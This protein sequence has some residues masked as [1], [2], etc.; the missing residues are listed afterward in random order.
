MQNKATVYYTI[1]DIPHDEFLNWNDAM[2][3]IEQQLNGEYQVVNGKF[4][5][6]LVDW[7]ETESRL[8]NIC[9]VELH[10]KHVEN[11]YYQNGGQLF[12]LIKNVDLYQL[13][14][15]IL[16]GKNKFKILKLHVDDNCFALDEIILNEME[17]FSDLYEI[18][19]PVS[20]TRYRDL[21]ILK[22]SF[23]I[24]DHNYNRV[25]YIYGYHYILININSN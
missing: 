14:M 19:N 10:D 5:E 18:K 6:N 20:N 12:I 24:Y 22:K 8:T 7:K 2:Q 25:L 1:D 17:H 15:S 21:Y 4:V 11:E 16:H 13:R 3:K 9:F 23:H